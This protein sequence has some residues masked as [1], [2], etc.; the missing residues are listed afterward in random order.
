MAGKTAFDVF[1][2]CGGLTL[3]LKQA[4][5]RVVGAVDIDRLA[6]TAYELN[7]PGATTWCVDVRDL[8]LEAI[9]GQLGLDRANSTFWRVALRARDSRR[10]ER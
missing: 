7:H 1:C 2:G 8:D 3:G 10:C 6:L 4:G 9:Q 5:F